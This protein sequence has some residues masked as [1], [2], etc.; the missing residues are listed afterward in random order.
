MIK[1]IVTDLDGTLLRS[2][3]TYS[4]EFDEVIQNL[5]HLG[6]LFAICSGRQLFN[7]KKKFNSELNIIYSGNNGTHLIIEN[8]EQ[9][10]T[11]EFDHIKK[12]TEIAKAYPTHYLL[13]ETKTGVIV[14]KRVPEKLVEQL[15]LYC[16]NLRF[17]DCLSESNEDICKVTICCL[18]GAEKY[19]YP[20]Y[21]KLSSDISVSL[22]G[23]IWLDLTHFD[24]HKGSAVKLIQ[25]HYSILPSET[26]VFGDH[27]NDIEML[28]DCPNS[29]AMK[30]AHSEAKKAAKYTLE[31][32][33]DEDGVIRKI[34]ELVLK[35]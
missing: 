4:E 3:K 21:Q 10:K 24:G 27:L 13:G 32:S 9:F 7:I 23:D 6:V 17:V 26:L 19:A 8:Q 11:L 16:E 14:E 29:Y 31:Y 2:D 28:K 35:S 22:S 15:K 33:N 1:L 18:E 30:N 12:I 20:H 5:N 25:E 34:K